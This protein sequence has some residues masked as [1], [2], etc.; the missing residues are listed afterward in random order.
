MLYPDYRGARFPVLR[1]TL[2]D[3]GVDIGGVADDVVAVS[4]FEISS[5]RLGF[6]KLH[7]C[8]QVIGIIEQDH[9]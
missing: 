8:G 5:G 4:Q 3:A 1:H 7:R 6:G 2:T 9:I